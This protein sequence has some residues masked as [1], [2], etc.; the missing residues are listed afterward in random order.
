M[1]WF[2]LK[3]LVETDGKSGR[4]M[5]EAGGGVEGSG[6]RERREISRFFLMDRA[7]DLNFILFSYRFRS[8]G[9][10]GLNATNNELTK[11]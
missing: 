2:G 3:G 5:L 6:E 9:L 1:T 10:T 4:A 7:W 11:T 8:N